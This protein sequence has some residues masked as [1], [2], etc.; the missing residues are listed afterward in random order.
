[1]K[2][3]A[4]FL[5]QLISCSSVSPE[6]SAWKTSLPP[7]STRCSFINLFIFLSFLNQKQRCSKLLIGL[8]SLKHFYPIM[9]HES[10]ISKTEYIDNWPKQV[11]Q[12]VASNVI[13]TT[14]Y[15]QTPSQSTVKHTPFG[16]W[17]CSNLESLSQ[18]SLATPGCSA[19]SPAGSCL[20]LLSVRIFTLPV[21]PVFLLLFVFH[22]LIVSYINDRNLGP[23]SKTTWWHVYV[24]LDGYTFSQYTESIFMNPRC[25][26]SITIWTHTKYY[27][28][29]SL[30]FSISLWAF[31]LA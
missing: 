24:S 3:H 9:L 25:Y 16:K 12:C 6:K 13:M 27:V 18:K 21:N 5:K 10:A 29:F 4:L 22:P 2:K 31:H 23:L 1:M 8:R 26:I 28:K 14:W 30:P 11:A 15:G 20:F 19:H 17:C 7:W